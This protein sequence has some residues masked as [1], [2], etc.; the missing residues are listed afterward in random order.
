VVSLP[1]ALVATARRWV[2]NYQ[3]WWRAIEA[4]SAI[5]RE[6][7]RRRRDAPGESAGTA[8]RVDRV[9]IAE[10]IGRG[11]IVGEGVHDLLGSPSSARVLGHVE[12][13][14]AS[15][16]VGQH[17]EDEQNAQARGGNSEEIDGNEIPDMIGQ[18]RAPRLRRR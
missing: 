8:A 13:E 7:L 17:D 4:V 3:A 11:G 1:P 9:A 12:V 5:N 16:I 6:L 14:D 10:E 15:A 18:E 2:A